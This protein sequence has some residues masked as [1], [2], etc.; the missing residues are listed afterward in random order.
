MAGS[1]YTLVVD[2]GRAADDGLPDG[3]TGATLLC[4]IAAGDEAEAVRSAVA[5]LKD[6]GL[7]PLDVTGYGSLEERLSE[8]PIE[9]EERALI[10]RAAA[11]GA[12]VVAEVTTRFDAA[13]QTSD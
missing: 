3:A 6:A 4:F 5:V 13:G 10:D 2:C 1:V 12:L 11:E 9:P 8:G 7:A